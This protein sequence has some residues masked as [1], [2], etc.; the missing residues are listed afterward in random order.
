MLFLRDGKGRFRFDGLD[1][2]PNT[3]IAI[4]PAGGAPWSYVAWS[5][6]PQVA[7]TRA[8][9]HPAPGTYVARLYAHG[10]YTLLLETASFVVE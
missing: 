7:G 2:A 6:V 5:Y 9:A 1:G 10:D 3:W 8:F 4:A